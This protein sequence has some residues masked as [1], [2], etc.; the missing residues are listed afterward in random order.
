[1]AINNQPTPNHQPR[2]PRSLGVLMATV[3]LSACATGPRG[4]LTDETIPPNEISFDADY[5][6]EL[7][8]SSGMPGD[9]Q[10]V[11]QEQ[12]DSA[13][14]EYTA[15]LESAERNNEL[16]G[17]IKD[18]AAQLYELAGNLDELSI[19][20]YES[21]FEG[22]L[23]SIVFEGDL[24]SNRYTFIIYGEES[25]SEAYETDQGDIAMDP[26]EIFIMASDAETSELRWHTSIISD[27]YPGNDYKTGYTIIDHDSD[28]EEVRFV[29]RYASQSGI[30][31]TNLS[32][33]GEPVSAENETAL[34]PE[35][36][37]RV[38][39]RTA[40][41]IQDTILRFEDVLE[42]ERAMESDLEG[43]LGGQVSP[44]PGFD[45]GDDRTHEGPSGAG[46]ETPI[47]TGTV[48]RPTVI[49]GTLVVPTT[50]AEQDDSGEEATSPRK[51]GPVNKGGS[52]GEPAPKGGPTPSNTLAETK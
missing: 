23:N 45:E 25:D 36:L 24:G 15:Y 28:D 21:E 1:M 13:G 50:I 47:V 46:E 34:V 12:V 42:N 7:N 10:M 20:G 30:V 19:S 6:K 38:D 48:P 2:I 39:N 3:A 35:D 9:E 41:I 49:N 26:S 16:R 40:G 32:H 11:E 52:A 51:G 14:P 27:H 43:Q 5:L 44:G 37:M 31:R 33:D 18:Q 4:Q 29:S 8:E 22:S 17:F